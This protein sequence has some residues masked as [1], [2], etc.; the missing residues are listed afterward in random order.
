LSSF[1]LYQQ[2][3]SAEQA[4]PVLSILK[5]HQIP[6]E[7]KQSRKIVDAVIA[8]ESSSDYLYEL[9]IPSNRFE[10]VNRLLQQNTTVNLD[11]LDPDYYLLSFSEQ[12]LKE[13]IQKP[14]EWSN[15]DFSIAR[16]LLE[17]QGI[18]YSEE[19]LDDIRNERMNV[20]ARPEKIHR[21]LRSAGYAFAIFLAPVGLIMGAVIWQQK[22]T[23]PNGR[24]EFVY[25]YSSRKEGKIIFI[26]SLIMSLFALISGMTG[27][28]IA[29]FDIFVPYRVGF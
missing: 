5:E 10:E 7:F 11:D 17:K 23:L 1:S 27:L 29:F 24:R 8:G 28:F 9:R 12:D 15:Q 22:K 18:T 19:D 16:I 21:K 6:F 20:L 26:I 2:F 3:F 4:E 13:I 25:D 14:D